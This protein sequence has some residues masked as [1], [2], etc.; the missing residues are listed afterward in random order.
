MR[1]ESMRRETSGPRAIADRLHAAALGLA[2]VTLIAITV[3]VLAGVF[4]RH[5]LNRPIPGSNE[6]IGS[7]LM[8]ALVYLSMSSADH[9]RITVFVKRL[10][11]RLRAGIDTAVL[12]VCFV[13]LLV[14]AYAALGAAIES[15][16]TNEATVGLWTFD[17]YPYRIVILLGLLL[18]AMRI[19]EKGR[20]WL[21]SETVEAVE[22]D[23]TA[24]SREG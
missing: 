16:V 17:I 23:E 1:Q 20:A 15:F 7:C 14:S 9:I 13:A 2:A 8:I 6:L 19:V 10:P 24:G 5:V 4:S 12:F 11:P 18:L 3:I 22:Q 21:S